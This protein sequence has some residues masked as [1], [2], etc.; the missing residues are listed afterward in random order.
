M[1]A[2]VRHFVTP[3]LE[4]EL[5][6]HGRERLKAI[7]NGVAGVPFTTELLRGR[8]GMALIQEVLR[9]AHDLL[10]RSHARDLAE[11]PNPYGAVDMELLR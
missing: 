1:P 6:D 9:S 10:V 8:P 2:G 5:I 11:Q 3:D 4:N 7:A